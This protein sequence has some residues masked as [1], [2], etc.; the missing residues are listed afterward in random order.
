MQNKP[1][2]DVLTHLRSILVE[3]MA[4]VGDFNKR[5][6]IIDRLF[7]V[8]PSTSETTLEATPV[9]V[10]D[11]EAWWI[12]P[13]D[14]V[15]GRRLLYVHGGSW[16]SG[17]FKGYRAFAEKIA[18]ACRCETLFINYPLAPE[19]P[20]PA[21]L[22]ACVGALEYIRRRGPEGL[23]TAD[24]VFVAGDSAGGNLTLASLL[25]N[26]QRDMP[27]VDAAVAISPC[28]DFTASGESIV[29]KQ[30]VDPIIIGQGIPLIAQVY[31]GGTFDVKNP[32]LSPLFGDLS[33]L[34]P[35][36]IQTGEA[37]VLLSDS[38]RFA[39][40]AGSQVE[41]DLNPD[42]PH[43][44]QGF[45]PHLPEATAAIERIGAFIERQ[46]SVKA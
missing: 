17:S 7:T 13:E 43:V 46:A 11:S 22:N 33:N 5:R 25:A 14:V 37:E 45:A 8:D 40:K 3:A 12:V 39:E 30:A 44:F 42:M 38:T 35:V 6:D 31:S 27:Q 24:K 16:V 29:T 2:D 10:E 41:L 1:L 34:P 19:N 15:P 36:L 9:T 20:Y 28:T 23:S 26:A 4:S 18:K 21:G 32:L